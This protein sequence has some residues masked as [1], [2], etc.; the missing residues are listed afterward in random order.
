MSV[1]VPVQAVTA[2]RSQTLPASSILPEK[3]RPQLDDRRNFHDAKKKLELI[4]RKALIKCHL[5]W[6]GKDP[7][8][9]SSDKV[10]LASPDKRGLGAAASTARPGIDPAASLIILH[11]HEIGFAFLILLGGIGPQAI[12][13]REMLGWSLLVQPGRVRSF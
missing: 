8:S 10:T 5:S 13:R 2:W 6:R 12:T 1:P 9:S 7:S 4:D 11:N 3:P